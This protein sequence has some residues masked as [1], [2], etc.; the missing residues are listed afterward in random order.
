[1]W[2]TAERSDAVFRRQLNVRSQQ[3]VD[4]RDPAVQGRTAGSDQRLHGP[5]DDIC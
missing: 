3:G 4:G 2:F 1:M 5:R